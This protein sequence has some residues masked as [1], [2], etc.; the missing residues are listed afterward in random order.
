MDE[1]EKQEEG[2]PFYAAAKIRLTEDFD[3]KFNIKVDQIRSMDEQLTALLTI[4]GRIISLTI[5][6]EKQ[7][8]YLISDLLFNGLPKSNKKIHRRGEVLFFEEFIMNAS[9]MSSSAKLKLLRILRKLHPFLIQNTEAQEIP[10]LFNEI[11]ECRNKFAHGDI[12]FKATGQGISEKPYLFYFYDNQPKEQLLNDVYFDGLNS[13][14][15]KSFDF[16][17]KLRKQIMQSFAEKPDPEFYI[18]TKEN[19]VSTVASIDKDNPDDK[20][21]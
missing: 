10:S 12:S 14:F 16:M 4:R 18:S 21:E 1:L 11:I 8:D 13:L 5:D 17:D 3:G 20:S 7:V 6:F 2:K 19:G 9:L 15:S